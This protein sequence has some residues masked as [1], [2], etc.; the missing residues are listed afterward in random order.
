MFNS[1]VRK[2]SETHACIGV[3]SGLLPIVLALVAAQLAYPQS[4]PIATILQGQLLT[5]KRVPVANATVQWSL[6]GAPNPSQTGVSDSAGNFAFEFPLSTPTQVQLATNANLYTP[7][8]TTV[9]LQ[10][11]TTTQVQVTLTRRPA[12]QY[13]AVLG[14][15]RNANGLV[16]PN[17]TVSILG[18]GDFLR[19]NTDANGKFKFTLIG[20]NSNLT[21][22]ASTANAPCIAATQVPFA[23]SS[24]YTVVSVKAPRVLSITANCPPPSTPPPP[25]PPGGPAA[26]AVNPLANDP[27]VLWQ[28]ADS[29]S[30]Q[31]NDAPNAWNAGHVND[32]VRL[33]PGQ[34][35]LVA[36]DEG[37]VWTIAED[38]SRTAV[39]LSNMWTSISMSAL[40]LGT[41]GPADV[42]AGTFQYGDSEGGDL[43]ETDTSQ[44]LPNAA[45]SPVSQLPKY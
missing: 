16:I 43:W 35:L 32:I 9:Q 45:S 18:A 27:T 41:G 14:A 5:T 33:P 26:H 37:G 1:T 15:V 34:G 13:G 2:C 40:A 31:N 10:P 28:Q 23:L 42:Y 22:Q 20:F 39:P 29:L 38:S 6:V 8:Q 24:T 21:L 7:T 36:S 44:S 19:T 4:Q 11:G 30:I 12:G 17:A 25:T 3:A